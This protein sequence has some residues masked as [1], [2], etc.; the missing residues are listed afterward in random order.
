[1]ES[2]LLVS[3]RHEGVSWIIQRHHGVLLKGKEKAEEE[4]RRQQRQGQR[5]AGLLALRW[6]QGQE[7]GDAGGPRKLGEARRGVLPGAPKGARPAR[8]P[9][10]AP[11]G[12]CQPPEIHSCEMTDSC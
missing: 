6:R 7:P 4:V 8:L 3:W 1:M 2:G 12:P 5:E 11:G 9:I 10:S